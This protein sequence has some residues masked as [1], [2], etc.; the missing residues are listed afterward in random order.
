MTVATVERIHLSQALQSMIDSRLDTIERM[1]LGR[2]PRA[3]RMAI[4]GEVESQIHE[5]LG[6][7]EAHDLSRE[8]VLAVLARLDPPE[9]YLPEDGPGDSTPAARGPIRPTVQ[10]VRQGNSRAARMSGILG[11][12]A[13]SLILLFPVFY[14]LA[15]ASGSELPLLLFALTIP[16]TLGCGTLGIVLSAYARWDGA[17]ALVGTV[18]SVLA[19]LLV[20]AGAGWLFLQR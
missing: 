14:M 15:L 9:A 19:L 18:T 8:D 2:V 1:L 11:I 13:L 7:R 16:I 17:W 5:L 12:V 20:L 3:E 10:S 6:E 4:V